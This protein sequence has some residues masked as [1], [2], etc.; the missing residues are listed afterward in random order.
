MAF[1]N[2]GLNVQEYVYDFAVDGGAVTGH[3]LSNKAGYDPIP[4]G[5]IVKA[6]TEKVVTTVTCSTG[7][8]I[9]WGNGDNADGYSGSAAQA[10][11]FTAGNLYTGWDNGSELLWDD[12]NDHPIPLYIDDATTGQFKMTVGTA[13]LTAGKI[14]FLVE[15]LLPSV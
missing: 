7:G 5:A 1:K 4:T 13:T 11:G 12:T 6:G 3:I 8:T 2:D 9:E 14:V 15:Y 10:S